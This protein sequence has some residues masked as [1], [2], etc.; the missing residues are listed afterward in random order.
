V[1][2]RNLAKN[3]EEWTA[4]L[5][6][7]SEVFLRSIEDFRAFA[8]SKRIT[9]HPLA[10]CDKATVDKFTES[11]LFKNGGLAHANYGVLKDKLTFKQ[12]E[13]LWAEFG[14]S[15]ELFMDHK[16]NYCESRATCASHVDYICMSSCN[17]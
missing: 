16:D 8:N 12:F 6:N 15:L 5:T 14:M 9:E 17:G 4:L 10:N 13:V 11:L 1:A 7:K 3:D 2:P